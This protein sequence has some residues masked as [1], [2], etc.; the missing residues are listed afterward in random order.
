MHTGLGQR[1][2]GPRT[3]DVVFFF[4][5]AKTNLSLTTVCA[6][7][8]PFGISA[9]QRQEERQHQAIQK[10]TQH[11]RGAVGTS[12]RAVACTF[13]SEP[14]PLLGAH[15]PVLS[16]GHKNLLVDCGDDL[17]NNDLL[18]SSSALLFWRSTSHSH[19]ASLLSV[20][21]RSP[22]MP[23][24]VAVNVAT[25]AFSITATSGAW[26]LALLF[27]RFQGVGEKLQNT[28][29]LA[30]LRCVTVEI[31]ELTRSEPQDGKI[32]TCLNFIHFDI[33]CRSQ[34]IWLPFMRFIATPAVSPRLLECLT[35]LTRRSTWQK[36]HRVISNVS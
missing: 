26:S 2:Q 14:Q 29:D 9:S 1:D 6:A 4:F 35:T 3:V 13:A 23:S 28:N 17:L 10:K 7:H 22:F 5:F 36:S 25:S 15:P 34:D 21:A 11:F 16:H 19:N 27:A 8:V 18:L 12:A 20:W 30:V 31:A 33:R 32:G 24:I